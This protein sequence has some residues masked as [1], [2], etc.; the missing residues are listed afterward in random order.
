M[1][2]KQSEA[3]G[4]QTSLIDEMIG[5]EKIVQAYSM[6]DNS[7]DRFDEI[8]GKLQKYSLDATFFHHF[9]ILQQDLS[10]M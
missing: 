6:E 10:T 8:N 2:K 4:E 3:R 9:P 7:L 1:F 5:N